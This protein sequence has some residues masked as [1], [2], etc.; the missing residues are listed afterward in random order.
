MVGRKTREEVI[1]E[2]VQNTL[3]GMELDDLLDY[4]ENTE[5]RGLQ[6]LSD[7][8]LEKLYV[9]MVEDYAYLSQQ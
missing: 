2:I 9:E 5:R 7:K 3:D 1:N 6:E 4:V 8:D